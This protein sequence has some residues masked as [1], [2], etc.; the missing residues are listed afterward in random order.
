MLSILYNLLEILVVLVPILLSVAFMTVIERKVMGSMQ[1]RI[2][3]NVVGYRVLCFTFTVK[4]LLTI[5]G[6]LTLI[7]LFNSLGFDP[8]YCQDTGEPANNQTASSGNYWNKGVFGVWAASFAYLVYKGAQVKNAKQAGSIGTLLVSSTVSASIMLDTNVNPAG[9]QAKILRAHAKAYP[10]DTQTGGFASGSGSYPIPSPL[11]G[12]VFD[13]LYSFFPS[14]VQ[15][16]LRI[17]V[18]SADFESLSTIDVL[19]FQYNLIVFILSFSVLI[20]IYSFILA[21]V[22]EYSVKNRESIANKSLLLSKLIPSENMQSVLLFLLKGCGLI[23]I[24]TCIFGLWFMYTHPFVFELLNTPLLFCVTKLYFWPT[25]CYK[26]FDFIRR[27]NFIS[28]V[29]K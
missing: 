10:N 14:Y 11:E 7:I 19:H 4:L 1:R 21:I 6:G 27:I 16:Q 3:P 9:V 15:Q 24:T 8:I 20:L 25:L 13:W 22:L 5:T 26:I 12:S 29:D 2:G 28:M 17:R 18:P 23:S